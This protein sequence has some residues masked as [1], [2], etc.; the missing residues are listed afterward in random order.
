MS[1]N[2]KY[3]S[4]RTLIDTALKEYLGQAC[5]YPETLKMSIEYSLFPG[6]KRLRPV[7]FLAAFNDLFDKDKKEG[8]ASACALEMIHTYSLIHDDLPAM[9]NDDYRRGKLTNHRVFGEAAAIL[10]GDALLNL[11]YE[12]MLENAFKYAANVSAHVKAM[13]LISYASGAKGMVAGQM[14][15]IEL[16]WKTS[17]EDT[18]DFICRNKTA[19]LIEVSLTA[20]AALANANDNELKALSSFGNSIGLA[21]QIIDD[22]SDFKIEDIKLECGQNCGKLTYPSVY[23]VEGSKDMALSLIGKAL[24]E[25]D[26]FGERAKFLREIAHF[27]TDRSE[28]GEASG[29][30]KTSI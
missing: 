4:Y 22:V 13:K 11:A 23:G 2:T 29:Y 20:A 27:I 18:L 16:Q 3:S 26:I 1:F 8:L 24:A 21:F 9:D 10:A 6:G 5:H 14:A 30:N 7:L 19:A 25:L 15:D 28:S 17:A 12:I